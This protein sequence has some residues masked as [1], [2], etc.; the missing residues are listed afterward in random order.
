MVRQKARTFKSY[1]FKNAEG[2][3]E[4]F[5]IQIAEDITRAVSTCNDFGIPQ[6]NLAMNFIIRGHARRFIKNQLGVKN[7]FYTRSKVHLKSSLLN[8]SIDFLLV[9]SNTKGFPKENIYR[10]MLNLKFISGKIFLNFLKIKLGLEWFYHKLSL[11]SDHKI[12]HKFYNSYLHTLI[13][14][15]GNSN[16]DFFHQKNLAF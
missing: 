1:R 12:S 15:I 3:F 2:Q 8:S 9:N 6:F 7:G 13:T 16:Y 11:L 5:Y 4:Q 10:W 14:I